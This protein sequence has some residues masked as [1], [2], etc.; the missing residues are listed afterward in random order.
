M[1]DG[2]NRIERR[3]QK[4]IKDT[5]YEVISILEDE[6]E[7]DDVFLVR[8]TEITLHKDGFDIAF[9]MKEEKKSYHGTV[10]SHVQELHGHAIYTESDDF[11]HI[12]R[13][14]FTEDGIEEIGKKIV[15]YL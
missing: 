9:T 6:W 7:G 13:T 1:T 8:E 3:I 11:I 10:V 12:N 15:Y 5:G 14:D 2:F 4:E